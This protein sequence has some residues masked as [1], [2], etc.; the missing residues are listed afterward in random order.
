MKFDHVMI[1]CVAVAM[2][3]IVYTDCWNVLRGEKAEYIDSLH[4]DVK[5]S[6][7]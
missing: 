3:G 4:P 7:K 5:E 2:Y 6:S 1:F